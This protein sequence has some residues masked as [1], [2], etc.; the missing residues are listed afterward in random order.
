MQK[1]IK[2]EGNKSRLKLKNKNRRKRKKNNKT[3]RSKMKRKKKNRRLLRSKKKENKSSFLLF[4]NLGLMSKHLQHILN[5]TIQLIFRK[6][7]KLLKEKVPM[8]KQGLLRDSPQEAHLKL[9]VKRN[10]TQIQ[11]IL[12]VFSPNNIELLKKPQLDL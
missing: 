4:R 11:M 3:R 2:I 8:V 6:K 7:F 12:M 5:E 1:Q 10:Q 9:Q